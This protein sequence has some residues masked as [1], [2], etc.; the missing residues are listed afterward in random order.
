MQTTSFQGISP[1]FSAATR[2]SSPS[3]V[4]AF[5]KPTAT[6]AADSVHFSGSPT[7]DGSERSTW[8]KT[9]DGI[10]NGLKAAFTLKDMAIDFGI[11]VALAI[12][13]AIIP[14]HVHA[15]AMIPTA[16]LV[17]PMFRFVPGAWRGYR[18]GDPSAQ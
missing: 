18:D 15:L 10:K 2:P 3:H 6:L 1:Q 17:G 9:K 11:G 4:R 12:A 14:P 13:T 16:M 5:Q 7:P 8:Q